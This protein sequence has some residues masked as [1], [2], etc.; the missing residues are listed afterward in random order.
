LKIHKL[1]CSKF[2]GEVLEEGEFSLESLSLS[3]LFDEH[4]SLRGSDEWIS[5]EFLPMIEDA[6]REGT[7]GG[8]GTESLGETE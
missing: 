4:T 1:T 5:T 3:D 7:T 8:G 6:L 2:V